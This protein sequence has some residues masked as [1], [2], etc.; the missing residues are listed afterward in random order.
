MIQNLSE[1]K[2]NMIFTEEERM[3]HR[4]ILE[5][6]FLADLGLLHGKMGIAIFFYEYAKR[7]GHPLFSECADDLLDDLWNEI[8]T[9]T[10]VDFANGLVGIGWGLE[11]LIQQGFVEASE[12]IFEEIDRRIMETDI[13]RI[14]NFSLETGLTGLLHYIMARIQGAIQRKIS[15]PFDSRYRLD[16]YIITK[17]I[18]LQ[19][20]NHEL[21]NLSQKYIYYYETYKEP[22]YKPDLTKFS[23][24]EKQ[25]KGLKFIQTATPS[26]WKKTDK[27]IKKTNEGEI[28]IFNDKSLASNYGIGTYMREYLYVLEQ[29]DCS[30]NLIE[31]NSTQ[32]T[33]SIKKDNIKHFY[34][35]HSPNEIV[36]KKYYLNVIKLLRLY[37]DPIQ[38]HIF[39][40][41][42]E[43]ADFFVEELKLHFPNSRTIATVHYSQWSW[44][45]NGDHEKYYR[46]IQKSDFT[47]KFQYNHLIKCYTFSKKFYNKIDRLIVLCKDTFELLH[48]I[49]K[50]PQEKMILIP[51]GMRDLKK[52]LSPLEKQQLKKKYHLNKDEKIILYVGRLQTSKGIQILLQAF[53]HILNKYESYRLVIV[54][55]GMDSDLKR[56]IE[57]SSDIGIKIT[58][59]GDICQ[60]LLFDWYQMADIGVLP[61]YLE[62]CSYVGIEMMMHQ[63]AVVASD[64]YGVR[65]M[66]KEDENALIAKIGERNNENEFIRNLTTRIVELLTNEE[67]REQIALYARNIY[68]DLYR[69][70]KMTDAYLRFFNGL[71]KG[72]RTFTLKKANL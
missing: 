4:L 65:N 17:R 23:I 8:N 35:P 25:M 24:N 30:I 69:I 38:T 1:I 53:T 28:F 27:E 54:G 26:L 52:N 20:Q 11:Y 13:R 3:I 15:I 34:I 18:M 39:H 5:S 66:F 32:P 50:L 59:T 10:P 22:D 36:N 29:I 33:Y 16:I 2:T 41:N 60:Q 67:K 64:A 21:K 14:T 42:Y 46:M 44:T 57:Q 48:E 43:Y 45:V 47:D 51:N 70:E 12:D 19:I 7:T 62:Q 37:I 9:Y 40:L 49:Y 68:E 72:S 71:F 61:S 56:T 55:G 58:F 31:L 63:L 6:S